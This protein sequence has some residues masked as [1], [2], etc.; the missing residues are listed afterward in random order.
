M[1]SV[2]LDATTSVRPSEKRNFFTSFFNK[3]LFLLLNMSIN[4]LTENN[5]TFYCIFDQPRDVILPSGRRCSYEYDASER[6]N[7]IRLPGNAGLI[8]VETQTGF[9]G[10]VRSAL[11]LP[12][13]SEPY[14]TFWSGNGQLLQVR[15]PGLVGISVFRYLPNGKLKFVA[16][17][18]S[19]TEFGYHNEGWLT[20]VDHE[21]DFFTMKWTETKP[22]EDGI[23]GHSITERRITFDSKS[24]F[25]SAKF[26]YSYGS[27]GNLVSV[28]GRIGGQTLPTHFIRNSLSLILSGEGISK[29]IGQFFTHVH[30]L[31]ET[32]ISDGVATYMRSDTTESLHISGREVY[33]AQY[34]RDSCGRIEGVLV[35]VVRVDSELRQVLK[36]KYDEDGQLEVG[37][38][39][40]AE[41][42]YAYDDN[43]NILSSEFSG[44][45]DRISFEYNNVGQLS[46]IK[47]QRNFYEYDLLGRVVADR[48]R[49]RISYESG[50][51]I[52]GV[53]VASEKG[54]KV[55]YFYD[56]LG[57]LSGRKDTADN[58]T[59]YFYG[60]PD[61][62]YLVSHVYSSRAGR[63]T[64]LIYDDTDQL[65]FADVEQRRYYVVCDAS[66]SPTNFMTPTGKIVSLMA[67]RDNAN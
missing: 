26:V 67:N 46:R 63:L 31:N 36:Y 47:G 19:L 11:K 50:D 18:S 59:Q 8:S 54:L 41:F 5:K 6:L 65:L 48:N 9:F 12:G 38:V 23:T 53:E 25:A 61:K 60:Y 49:N 24:G 21:T 27:S 64:T 44:S 20:R 15:P 30:N 51:L 35:K 28:A 42:R 43:G 66:G 7:K 3:K 55:T 40:G 14:V 34:T 1:N 45:A 2:N 13:I 39:D 10:R 52:S 57:R 33:S 22:P 16:S 37:S 58:S 32:T 4:V 29:D 56:H 17:G 62:P